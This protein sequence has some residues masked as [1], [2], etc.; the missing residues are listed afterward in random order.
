MKGILNGGSK[1]FI[2]FEITSEEA[3]TL[4]IKA[5]EKREKERK[6]HE[7]EKQRHPEKFKD[8]FS[9][10]EFYQIMARKKI[11]KINRKIDKVVVYRIDKNNKL[12]K[13]VQ[14]YKAHKALAKHMATFFWQDNI[15]K[16]CNHINAPMDEGI[17][18]RNSL[19]LY[20]DNDKKAMK[21]FA[22][23]AASKIN[24]K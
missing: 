1:N 19:F 17:V 2:N 12:V 6:Q 3:W 8:E 13:L 7:R 15:N 11:K 22:K 16:Y 4:R 14:P 9:E 18:I 23:N 10:D 24:K 5:E 21:L 20:E